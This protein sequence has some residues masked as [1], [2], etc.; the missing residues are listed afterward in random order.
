M[1]QHENLVKRI[2]QF[3][4]KLDKIDEK[5][6]SKLDKILYQTT[7]TNGQVTILKSE[8]IYVQQKVSKVEEVTNVNK[9]RD[10]TLW[11]VGCAVGAIITLVVGHFISKL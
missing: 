9:G 3:E 11:I 5:Y 6:D 8:M 4:R 7:K 2:D 10:T 1:E